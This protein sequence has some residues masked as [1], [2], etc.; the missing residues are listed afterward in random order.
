M[1]LLPTEEIGR[2]FI[3]ASVSVTK[4]TFSENECRANIQRLVKNIVSYVHLIKMLR[5]PLTLKLSV[6]SLKLK[7]FKYKFIE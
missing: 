1:P 6:N 4:S 5:F 3:G 7:H 2:V